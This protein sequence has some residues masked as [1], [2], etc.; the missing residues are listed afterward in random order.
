[1]NSALCGF[2]LSK[3]ESRFKIPGRSAIRF[4]SND[5]NEYEGFAIAV[6]FSG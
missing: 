1:M 3:T 5:R 2:E 4:R 6:E